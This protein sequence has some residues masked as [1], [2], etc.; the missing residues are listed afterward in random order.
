MSLN[1]DKSKWTRVKLGDVAAAS[2]EKIDPSA[3]DVDRYIAGEHMDT[4]DLRI[5]RWG[6]VREVDLGP[7]FHRRFRP[8]QVLYG[9][10]RTYLRKVAVAEFDGV[11]AN[12]TYVVETNDQ[13]VLLQSLL[14]F[15]MTSEAFHAFAIG[16]SKGSVNPYVNWSDIARYEFDL[17]P[18]EE[19]ENIADLLWAVEAH[20]SALCESEI[21]SAMALECLLANWWG[22]GHMTPIAS[23]GNC[24]TGSTPPK[25]S[26]QFWDTDEVPFFTPTE[27][28][29]DTVSAPRQW[30]SELGAQRGRRLL[31]NSVLVACIGGDM[32]KSS[33][34]DRT[35][36]TNQQITA[37]TGLTSDEAYLVQA[38][39]SHPL[40]R[41]A[42]ASRETTTIVRKLNKSDLMEVEIPWGD[43]RAEVAAKV[44]TVRRGKASIQQELRALDGLRTSLLN[45]IFGDI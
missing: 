21:R 13:T 32:G 33:V 17:P 16:E 26:Q 22:P 39:L 6:D 44:D 38:L 9:S 10:R 4:D 45:E 18:I 37:I 12:T 30:V 25:A 8:G 31:P 40:G 2:R 36:I 14:P 20:R 23:I 28:Q 35:G 24:V 11:C 41:R 27:I 43:D 5:N 19:Q 3:G 34:L 15:V 1:L 42:T 29:G 7:A